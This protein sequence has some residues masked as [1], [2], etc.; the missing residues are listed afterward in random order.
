MVSPHFPPDTSAGAH[1]VRLLAPHLPAFGWEPT[2]LTVDPEAYEGR[3]DPDLARLVPATLRVLR[4]GAWPA[5]V[6][7][8]I[9]LGDLGL[10]ALTGLR[11]AA[12]ELLSRERFDA[13]FI[14]VY[15]TYPAVLGPLNI[16]H[17]L[18]L[19]LV[20]YGLFWWRRS[21]RAELRPAA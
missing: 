1:R 2:V 4:T 3:L 8:R 21:D 14:T 19:G 20:A 15:P 10:R 17:L 11:H 12:K 5:S 7:R 16:F 18:M 6:T 13:L 9:G